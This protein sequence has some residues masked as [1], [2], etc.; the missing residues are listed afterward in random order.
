MG[1][2]VPGRGPHTSQKDPDAY[3]EKRLT[4]IQE[5]AAIISIPLRRHGDILG[6]VGRRSSTQEI[7]GQVLESFQ[8][9][10]LT[11]FRVEYFLFSLNLRLSDDE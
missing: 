11:I 3:I 1:D 10:F 9:P 5:D 4:R 7:P 8:G 6:A 2:N